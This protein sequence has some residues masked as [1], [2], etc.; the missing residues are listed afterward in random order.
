[1]DDK[2]V[3]KL[4]KAAERE[5]IEICDKLV[6]QLEELQDLLLRLMR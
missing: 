6:V 5:V 1:M 4:V 2:D 3:E